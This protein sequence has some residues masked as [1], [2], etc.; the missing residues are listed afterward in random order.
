MKEFF[1]CGCRSVEHILSFEHFYEEIGNGFYENQLLVTTFLN[2]RNS[3]FYRTWLAIRYV[4]GFKAKDRHY[5]YTIIEEGDIP[6][7]MEL[8]QKVIDK[9][10][11]KQ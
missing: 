1:E 7:L 8:C 10:K 4:F 5:D 2:Q 9:Q 3:I 6:R 11:T